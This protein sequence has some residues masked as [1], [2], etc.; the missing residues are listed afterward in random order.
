MARI[1]RWIYQGRG[2]IIVSVNEHYI[3]VVKYDP[4]RGNSCIPLPPELQHPRK[5][6]INIQ[7]EDNECFRWCHVRYINPKTENPQQIKNS[8][9]EMVEKLNY[10]GVEFPVNVKDYGKVEA[11]NSFNVNVFGYEDRQFFPIYV[12]KQKNTGELNLLLITDEE[13]QHYVLI[14]DL[15]RMMFNISKSHHRERFCMHCLKHFTRKEGLDQHRK[16]CLLIHGCHAFKI[17]SNKGKNIVEFR[18]YH[19]QMPVPFVIYAGFEAVTKN[20]QGCQPY[21]DKSYTDK[22]QKHTACSCGYKLVCF[23]DDKYTK[24]VK[25]YRGEDSIKNFMKQMLM[26][27]Q[28]SEKIISSG[29]PARKAR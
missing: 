21:A 10:Q 22:Y 2:Y 19:K 17:P 9:R 25:I 5:G 8:D 3:N 13:K 27:V 29:A 26:E 12:S 15:D 24:P 11:K 4:L 18:N 20:V 23:Y 1:G 6:L 7:N 16:N 14:K 28:Y